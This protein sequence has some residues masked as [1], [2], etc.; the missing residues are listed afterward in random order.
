VN[1]ISAL[2]INSRV[3]M[4]GFENSSKANRLTLSA[5]RTNSTLYVA[6]LVFN[7]VAMPANER[8]QFEEQLHIVEAEDLEEAFLKA[9]AIGI[10]Q[11]EIIF[12]NG[13]PATKWEFIDVADLV[14]IPSLI[15]STEIYS[16]I[17]E[18]KEAREYIDTVHQRGKAIRLTI[19][20]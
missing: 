14:V 3:A 1:T 2:P 18:T 6:K 19:A 20:Q 5:V 9:R 13:V 11:E 15:K 7:I 12:R 8:T 16:H 17:H 4:P 10:G